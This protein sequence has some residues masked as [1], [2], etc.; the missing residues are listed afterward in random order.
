MLQNIESLSILVEKECWLYPLFRL[1][2]C[3]AVHLGL[4]P[5]PSLSLWVHP[6][7]KS[8]VLRAVPDFPNTLQQQHLDS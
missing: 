3:L 2:S 8:P 6:S 5:S 7:F 1:Q 4:S